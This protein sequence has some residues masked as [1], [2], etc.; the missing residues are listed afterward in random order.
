MNRALEPT[1]ID[2]QE[3]G[4]AS[5][6][7]AQ[8]RALQQTR[9]QYA[10]AV[11]VQKPRKLPDVQRRVLE[12]AQLAGE[13]FYYGWT[14]GGERIEGP[15]VDL[16]L[17][18]A[19]CWGNCAVEPMPVQ[20]AGDSWIFTAAFVD[21]ETGFT[22]SRQFRQSKNSKV[23]GKLDEERKADIRFQIGQSKA[24]RNVV[25]N[26]LP[27]SL[28]NRAMA[29]AKEGVRQKIE[30]YVADKGLP[31]AVD[32]VVRALAKCGVTEAA[33]LEKFGAAK[34]SAIDIDHLVILRG[35]LTALENGR[36]RV[37]ALYPAAA[38]E[39]A[40]DR[41]KEKLSWQDRPKTEATK[42]EVT[43]PPER[44]PGEDDE[45]AASPEPEAPA[46]GMEADELA[47]Q[48][49]ERI[50]YV[51]LP[52]ELQA[53]GSEMVKQRAFLGEERY[54]KLL[55]LFQARN[56]EMEK[57]PASSNPAKKGRSF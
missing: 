51:G 57:R 34:R 15:S 43:A 6:T 32:Y 22:L 25:L 17:S 52:L 44:Q 38:K 24:I 23:H 30:A 5:E 11:S 54:G 31:A 35:D 42:P 3:N 53:V 49:T 50:K 1:V 9:T 37:E 21:L 47:T 27:P 28:I 26:A 39:A 55:G 18:A 48:M 4:V 14:A 56:K 45:P 13:D 40:T 33:I 12:E 16:A 8:G 20:D 10:T 2:H 7:L 29:A 36:E 41:V 19:R 46:D